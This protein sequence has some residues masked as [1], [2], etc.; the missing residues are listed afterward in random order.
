VRQETHNHLKPG[1]ELDYAVDMCVARLTGVGDHIIQPYSTDLRLA[2]T[3]AK[4][5]LSSGVTL[6]SLGWLKLPAEEVATEMCRC[7]LDWMETTP[8]PGLTVTVEEADGKYTTFHNAKS[9]AYTPYRL[10]S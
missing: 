1:R 10:G 9:V 6:Y 2:W 5:A 7:F 3:L 4:L 8:P